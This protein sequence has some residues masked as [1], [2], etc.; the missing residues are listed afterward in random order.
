MVSAIAFSAV[1][2]LTEHLTIL[3][4]RFS[5]FTPCCYVVGIHFALFPNLVCRSIVA[6]ST[7]GTIRYT[8]SLSFLCLSGIDSSL[9][10]FVKYADVKEAC[11]GLAAQQV[12][13]DTPT[14]FHIG[15]GV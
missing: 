6:D 8:G 1:M 4:I 3:Y 5:A 7:I 15:V 2:M 10:C 13:E 9:C 12:L 14:V 11:I